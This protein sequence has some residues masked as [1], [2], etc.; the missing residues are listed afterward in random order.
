M[1]C[2]NLNKNILK[3]IFSHINM[4]WGLWDIFWPLAATSTPAST[5]GRCTDDTDTRRTLTYLLLIASINVFIIL[6]SLNCIDVFHANRPNIKLTPHHFLS[7]R[8]HRI[9]I[10]KMS[11]T[12]SYL[13]LNRC[14]KHL[15]LSTRFKNFDYSDLI[16]VVSGQR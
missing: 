6:V 4:I 15:I 16:V 14:S 1:F 12:C 8:K 2:D 9:V 5:N 13:F 11:I 7:K 3:F 10:Y